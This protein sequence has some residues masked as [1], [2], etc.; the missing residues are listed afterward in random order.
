MS[1]A[2][3]SGL[4]A[5]ADLRAQNVVRRTAKRFIRRADVSPNAKTHLVVEEAAKALLDGFKE[6][7]DPKLE[8]RSIKIELVCKS[9]DTL[10]NVGEFYPKAHEIKSVLEKRGFKN[11]FLYVRHEKSDEL[12]L[13][14]TVSFLDVDPREPF[15]GTPYYE[16]LSTE[17]R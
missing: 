1:D 10:F 11:A 17:E 14:F 12:A 15:V 9:N 4:N 5:M 2:F 3:N 16:F 13:Y 7:H 8:A 6:T